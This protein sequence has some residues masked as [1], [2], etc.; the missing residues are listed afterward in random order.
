M[1]RERQVSDSIV[2][3]APA[4]EVFAV[5]ADPRQHSRFDGS[6]TVRGVV[7]GP[8]RLALGSR[9]G[10]R[11]RAGLPYRVRNTVVEFEQDRR[12]AWRHAGRHVWRYDLEPVEGG[13]RV[14]ETFDWTHARLRLVFDVTPVPRSNARAITATL[15]RLR[16][17]VEGGR[18]RQE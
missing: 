1:T 17:L 9:F 15:R 3:A 2:I 12:I 5:L 13:T 6:G 18:G 4:A 7:T 16:E 10:M 8:D 11:M 14:T